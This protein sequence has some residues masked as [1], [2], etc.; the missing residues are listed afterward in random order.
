LPQAT[1]PQVSLLLAALRSWIAAPAPHATGTPLDWDLLLK[2]A[3]DTKTIGF[4]EKGLQ[5]LAV[6]APPSVRQ[7]LTDA[8]GSILQSNMAQLAETIGCY[9]LLTSRGIRT[10]VFKGVLGQ[11]QLYGRV[12]VRRSND[13]DLLVMAEDYEGARDTLTEGGFRP[14]VDPRNRWWHVYLGEAPYIPARPSR[15]VVDLHYRMQQPGAPAPRHSNDFFASAVEKKFGERSVMTLAPPFALLTNIVG[16]SKALRDR[17]PWLVYAHEIAFAVSR[18][19]EADRSAFEVLARRQGLA[20]LSREAIQASQWLF[21]TSPHCAGS[22]AEGRPPELELIRSS[23]GGKSERLLRRST[24]RWRW[25]DGPLASRI[26]HF[27][28]LTANYYA[29]I[30]VRRREELKAVASR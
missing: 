22:P 2:L 26:D 21:G 29:S 30:L 5:N 8:R 1:D 16:Y 3:E 27:A 10:L 20:R 15:F 12:D 9:H 23:L 24:M 11:Q 14:G 4:L 6:E 19:S 7:A 18:M 17:Q 25:T 13:I 28:R